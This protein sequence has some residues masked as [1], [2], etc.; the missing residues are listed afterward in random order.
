M[1]PRP[2]LTRAGVVVA[3]V[4]LLVLGLAACG[5]S[6]GS[7]S[8]GGDGA[9]SGTEEYVVVAKDFSLTDLTVSPGEQFTLDNQGAATHT[10]TADDG[11]F[12]SGEVAPGEQSGPLT[13]PSSPGTYPYHC[14]IHASMT[15]TLTVE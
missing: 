6:D 5:S 1:H 7:T 8:S 11:S 14:E 3:G 12:D 9:E 10:L 4:L 15:G 13:P 2:T